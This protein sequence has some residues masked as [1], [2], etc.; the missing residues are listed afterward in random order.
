MTRFEMTMA[1]LSCC[2]CMHSQ[3]ENR[4]SQHYRHESHHHAV[5]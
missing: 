4:I 5:S 3:K 1:K 2:A